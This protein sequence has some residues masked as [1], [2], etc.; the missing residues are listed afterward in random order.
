MLRYKTLTL[1]VSFLFS[2]LFYGQERIVVISDIDDTI[3]F[4]GHGRPLDP[5]FYFYR[6]KIYPELRDIYRDL[7]HAYAHVDFFYISG[8]NRYLFPTQRWLEESGFPH[9]ETFLRAWDSGSIYPYKKRTIKTILESYRTG[10][11]GFRVL[12]FGDNTSRDPQI[13]LDIAEEYELSEYQIFIRTIRNDKEQYPGIHYFSSEDE[14]KRVLSNVGLSL[15]EVLKHS[16]PNNP[17]VFE[18]LK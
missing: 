3:K 9:G 11:E 17:C 6:R 14:V 18:G 10:A 15:P 2:P 16:R 1:L 5:I 7:E 4:R 8:K 12:F 13:Y